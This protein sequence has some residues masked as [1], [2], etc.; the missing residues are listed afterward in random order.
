MH[1]VLKFHFACQWLARHRLKFAAKILNNISRVIFSCDIK[2][3]TNISRSTKFYHNALGV[4]IHPGSV[5]GPNVAIY[6]NVTLGGNGKEDTLNGPPI[7][8]E[9]AV[10][11]AGAKI[12]GPVKVGEYAIVGANA[13]VT[14]D[15]PPNITVV[16]VPARAAH[17]T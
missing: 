9:G 1:A 15:V 3:S 2:Y 17:R 6:Q 4:V 16:G 11:S 8:C 13:V 10:I 7:I 14:K 12:L 5:I